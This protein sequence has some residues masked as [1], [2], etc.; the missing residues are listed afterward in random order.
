V[1]YLQCFRAV[2]AH[3]DYV[4]VNISSPNTDRLRDLQSAAGLSQLICP[5]Q[6]EAARLAREQ[7]KGR[8][9]FVKLAPD[10]SEDQLTSLALEIRRLGVDGVIT[11]NTS[12]A[13]DGVGAIPA[14][15]Q[16]GGLSGEPLH[17]KSIAVITKLRAEL[18]VEFP[19]IGVGGITTA[20]AALATLRAGAN[21]VQVYTGL[22]YRGPD[23]LQEILTALQRR[24]RES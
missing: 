7:G 15:Y 9:I 21:L 13:L 3:A 14:I 16:G 23:L 10:L 24:P 4:A 17:R 20:D 6:E 8:P 22:V 11:T 2:Y 5:L 18:G 1:D 12:V 19:I